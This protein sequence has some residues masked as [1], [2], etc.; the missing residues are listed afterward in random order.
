M[1]LLRTLFHFPLLNVF[2]SVFSC[3]NAYEIDKTT[4]ENHGG[5]KG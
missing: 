4:N 1:Q 5:T 3:G 2:N